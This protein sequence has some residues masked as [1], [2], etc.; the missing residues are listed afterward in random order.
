MMTSVLAL[1]MSAGAGGAWAQT[2]APVQTTASAQTSVQAQAEHKSKDAPASSDATELTSVEVTGSRLQ[3]GDQTSRVV[4]ITKEEIEARGVTSV[5]ELV[6]TLP[7]NVATIGAITNERGRGP[8]TGRGASS[9]SQIGSLG[10]SAANLGGLGAGNTLILVNGRRVAGAAGIEDGF[11]NLNGV[12]L[13]AID[14]VEITYGGAS[15][16]YGADAIGGVINFILK[17]DFVGSTLTVQHEVSS[18]DAD[19]SR[20]SLYSG[21]SWGSGNVSG[22]VSYARRKPVN[23]YKSG[24]TTENYSSYYGGD[25]AFDTRSFSRGL[26]PGVIDVST[27]EMDPDT[28][29]FY[30]VPQGMTVRP[31]L[32]GRPSMSDFITV[33][34]EALPD[35]VPEFAGP[36]SDTLGL[37]FNFEQKLTS[38][39]TFFGNVLYN[40]IKSEQDIRYSEGLRI[41]LAPGQAYNPFSAYYFNPFTAG[42]QVA[43]NPAAEV[44]AGELP[45]GRISNTNEQLNLNAGLSYQL[46]TDTKLE[47]LYTKSSS[48]TSGQSPTL[49][50]VVDFIRDDTSPNGVS[51]YNFQLAQNQLNGVDR[52]MLQK[53]FD[54]QCLVLTSSDPTQA[55]NPWKSTANGGGTSVADFYYVPVLENRESSMEN[56]EVR[57]TGSAFNLPGGKIFYAV[58]AELTKDGTSSP[59]VQVRTL[60]PVTSDQH[61][62]FGEINIPVFG[63][64]FNFPGARSLLLNFA[65]RRDSFT[66]EGPVG[67]VDNIPITQGGT[68]IYATNTFER[69]TPAAGLRWEPFDGLAVRARW[70]KG[71][72]AP[73]YTQLFD[74]TGGLSYTTRIYND[75]L[76]TCTTDCLY[77]GSNSYDVRQIFAPNPD[78]KPQISNQVTYGFTWRPKGMLNGLTLDVAYNKTEI[79]SEYAQL[80]ELPSLLPQSEIMKIASFYPRDANGK[81]IEVRNMP[82]NIVGSKY[83]SISYELSYLWITDYGTFEPKINVLDNLVAQR[84]GFPNRDPI[85]TIGTLQGQDDYRVTASMGWYYHDINAYLWAYYIPKYVNDYEIYRAAGVNIYENRVIPVDD[86]LT[87]DFTAGWRVSNDVRLNFAGRNILD[88]K[89]PFV[90]VEGRPYD[91]ARYNAAG[92]TFSLE[93]QYSF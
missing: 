19:N 26:Q 29:D 48:K 17:K 16:I 3:N 15:A 44:A 87:I 57:A 27:Y 85:S 20:I 63:D 1:A 41:Q 40:K 59:E 11:A 4:V 38:R 32:V 51:C 33:G 86:M 49:G 18:N 25:T 90:V 72:K 21:Y 69:T 23:N 84:Q 42:P 50:S 89:P 76:Y 2:A 88:Q 6:R 62:Y 80:R 53:V 79:D 52:D 22:S 68:L 71:F 7:Q 54:R 73:P 78:L 9:V 81:I 46:N 82:F 13:S 75:P 31:G 67:T 58:G 12:P 83:S 43:Y 56:W 64:T 61:A 93:L 77:P 14:R 92:R 5:E 47:L 66:T 34:A 45:V 37:T 36:E 60:A 55:F 91:T 70:T 74:P 30:L 28:F 35:V 10:V 65:A 39:L 8:L 24:Y